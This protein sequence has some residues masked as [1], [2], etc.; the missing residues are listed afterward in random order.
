MVMPNIVP[1]MQRLATLQA[2]AVP[3]STAYPYYNVANTDELVFMNN[4]AG[5]REATGEVTVKTIL[6]VA[7]MTSNVQTAEYEIAAQGYIADVIN[8]CALRPSMTIVAEPAT[9]ELL[10][11]LEPDSLTVESNGTSK[12]EHDGQDYVGSVFTFRFSLINGVTP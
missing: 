7:P 10:Q 8:Y 9:E 6:R 11:Y 12:I 5:Y 2:A 1:F 3:G 4:F